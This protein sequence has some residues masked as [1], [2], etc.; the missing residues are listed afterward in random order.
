MSWDYIHMRSDGWKAWIENIVYWKIAQQGWPY[1]ILWIFVV[2][3]FWGNFGQMLCRRG[4]C[5]RDLYKLYLRVTVF[6]TRSQKFD[7]MFQEERAFAACCKDTDWET[8]FLEKC[9]P[10]TY[11]EA[12]MFCSGNKLSVCDRWSIKKMQTKCDGVY[13]TY[14]MSNYLTFLKFFEKKLFGRV[15]HTVSCNL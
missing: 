8:E 14:S 3:L 10:V 2:W 15:K 11:F 9:S 7:W 1:W 6:D 13:W 4:M 5:I 12:E